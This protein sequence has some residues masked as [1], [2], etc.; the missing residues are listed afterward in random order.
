MPHVSYNLLTEG[1]WKN[2]V[3]ERNKPHRQTDSQINYQVQN[4]ALCIE[5]K[6][7]QRDNNIKTT[8]ENPELMHRSC[9]VQTLTCLIPSF[10]RS[11][12]E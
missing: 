8:L 11:C 5:S 3:E 1:N 6:P 10:F 7:Q 9:P 12:T 2:T 4:H